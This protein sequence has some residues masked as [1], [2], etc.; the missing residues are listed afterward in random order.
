MTMA[1]MD[2]IIFAHYLT[3]VGV[4]I[5]EIDF[6][7][8]LIFELYCIIYVPVFNAAVVMRTGGE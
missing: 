6:L 4:L 5:L 2:R 8:E 1:M 3:N 7:I